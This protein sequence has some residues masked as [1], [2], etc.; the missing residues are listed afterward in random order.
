MDGFRLVE[1]DSDETGLGV[2]YII[3][4]SAWM[5]VDKNMVGRNMV[6]GSLVGRFVVD[7]WIVF[8]DGTFGIF[9]WMIVD[10]RFMV[11]L[12]DALE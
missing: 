11:G 7:S 1:V 3:E 4:M 6:D 5:E 2:M 8:V 12:T 10:N 9:E